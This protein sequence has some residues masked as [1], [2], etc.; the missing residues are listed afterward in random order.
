MMVGN[1]NET[2]GQKKVQPMLQPSHVTDGA[3]PARFALVHA[4]GSIFLP[5]HSGP[6]RRGKER[7]SL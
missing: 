7:A 4:E 2:A 6:Q 3:P 1:G 5:N